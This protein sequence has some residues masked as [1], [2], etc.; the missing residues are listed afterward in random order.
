MKE[1]TNKVQYINVN[2]LKLLDNNPRQIT[3]DNF[4]KLKKSI[5][6]NPNYFEAR[7]LIIS[8]RTSENIIIAGNQRYKAS[9]ELGLNEVPCVILSNLTED[10]EKEIIIR[11]NVE[12]GDWDYDLLV[13]EWD[14]EK[15]EDWGVKVLSKEENKSILDSIYTSKITSPIYEP[16]AEIQPNIS[17]CVN[18]E[19][20][21]NFLE[22]IDKIEIEENKKNFLKLLAT[23]FIEF[24]FR[25]IAEFYCHE[26]KEIQDIMEKM[27]CV[28]I[29]Y[30]KAIENG[31]VELALEV[32]NELLEEYG[33]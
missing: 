29:D 22:L 27:A 2:E 21:N 20:Y 14:V 8:N 26:N 11:D 23:R 31:Y 1:I 3:K 28:I 15:L 19:K 10:K 32:N 5:K 9:L 13:N 25:N 7:P 17:E 33:E 6:D 24:N 12:L 16:K 4:N 30:N 18:I